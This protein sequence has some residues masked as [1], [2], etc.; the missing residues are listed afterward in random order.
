MYRQSKL[1]YLLTTLSFFC[2]TFIT[3]GIPVHASS[4]KQNAIDEIYQQ[5][6]KESHANELKDALPNDTQKS[7]EVIGV[8]GIDWASFS[9]VTPEK[10]FKKILS[11]IKESSPKPIKS[12]FGM[13]AV[14]LLAALVDSF[15]VSLSQRP[16]S[17][18]VN[19]I[20]TLCI[21][22]MSLEPIISFIA[23]ASGVIK[24]ASNFILCYVPVM[25]GIM[26]ASGQTVSATSYNVLMI[27]AGEIISQVASRLITPLLSVFL[28][29]STVSSIS[30]SINLN[31][32]CKT[33]HS[34]IKWSLGLV[35]TIFV[36]LL[37]LQSLVGNSADSTT[38]KATKFMISSFVPIVG[39][40]LGDAL[41]SV[42]SCVKLLKSGV[43][44]FGII[45]ASFIF[46]PIIIEC[47]IWI[48]T[49]NTC[50]SISEIFQ[51][52]KIST[53]LKGAGTVVSTMLSIIL[54][55]MLIL[56]V[57]TVIVLILGGSV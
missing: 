39:G 37:T 35:M 51:L 52:N 4:E 43:G 16:L 11:Y 24:G 7:L 23:R 34:F 26:M 6:I 48:A 42:Q 25:T 40:A 33:F 47:L 55:S 31:G 41:G 2:L 8:H 1:V 32:I 57:S 20:A 3:L 14:I 36:S 49:M 56:T 38:L 18:T 15:K 5:Q 30:T 44:A 12:A 21:C 53:L 17:G 28:A 46:L 50:S 29:L 10:I 45:A 13:I 22:T 9:N 19:V 27:T 54:C